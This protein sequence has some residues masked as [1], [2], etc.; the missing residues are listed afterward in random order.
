M[1]GFFYFNTLCGIAVASQGR[2]DGDWDGRETKR[3]GPQN[4]YR[5]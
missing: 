1:R 2:I 4:F 5:A 3:G